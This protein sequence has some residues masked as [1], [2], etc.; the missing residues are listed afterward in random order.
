MVLIY[1]NYF[2][3]SVKKLKLLIS[4]SYMMMIVMI[5]WYHTW[6]HGI[7]T[8]YL[9][10]VPSPQP[11]TGYYN[12]TILTAQLHL[13]LPTEKIQHGSLAV[14]FMLIRA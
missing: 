14:S 10:M 11:H 9:V 2:N 4:V 1:S 12:E 3:G 13:Q 5:F 8:P 7:W 6:Y